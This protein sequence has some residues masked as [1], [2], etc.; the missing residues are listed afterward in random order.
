MYL[1]KIYKI[2]NT[3]N[4]YFNNLIEIQQVKCTFY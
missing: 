3:T 1:D 4:Y 2:L